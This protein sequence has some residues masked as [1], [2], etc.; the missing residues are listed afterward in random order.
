MRERG[1]IVYFKSLI[2]SILAAF[3]FQIFGSLREILFD[4]KSFMAPW[5]FASIWGIFAFIF[6]L[7]IVSKL[8]VSVQTFLLAS[9]ISP[10]FSVIPALV[11][12]IIFSPPPLSNYIANYYGVES[13]FTL[14]KHETGYANEGQDYDYPL[15]KGFLYRKGDIENLKAEYYDKKKA[16]QYV[17]LRGFY[18]WETGLAY[19]FMPSRTIKEFKGAD[20]LGDRLLLIITVGPVFLLE[21]F[22]YSIFFSP[23]YLLA[24]ILIYFK[25]K[26]HMWWEE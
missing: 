13:R 20:T 14:D 10:I 15:V 8:E 16:N 5:T 24:Q 25:Y 21:L 3:I 19:G 4:S 7:W 17:S 12:W 23:V 9:F 26:T 22:I 11:L 1:K 2:L 6:V 18:A